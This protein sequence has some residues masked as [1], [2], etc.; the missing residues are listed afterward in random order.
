M[1]KVEQLKREKDS[2][3]IIKDL[4]RFAREGWESI[5]DDDVQRL[6]WYGLFL[7]TPTPGLFM[8]RVRIP[9]GLTDASQ[10]HTLGEISKN[11]GNGVIDITTR[12]QI[13]LRGLKIEDTP[14]VFELMDNVGLTSIQTGQDNVRNIMGCPVAGLNP[15]EVLDASSVLMDLNRHIQGNR[16]FTDLPRKFNAMISGCADNCHHAETQDLALIPAERKDSLGERKGFNVLVGGKLGSGGYRIASPLDVFVT[17]EEV[18]EVCSELILTYRDNGSREIRTQNRLAFL[19]DEWGEERFRRELE[20]RLGRSLDRAGTDLRNNETSKHIGIYRQKQSSMNYIGIRIVVGRISAEKLIGLA[21]VAEQYG[22]GE[23]RLSPAQTMIIPNVADGILGEALEHPLL[24]EFLYYPSGV[25]QDLVS[26]VGNDYC[27]LATIETKSRAV[28]VATKLEKT[29][30]DTVPISMHWSGCPASCGNHLIAD[31]GLLGKRIKV[32]KEV[33]DGVD[34]FMGGRTGKHPKQAIKI[35]E[36]VP[37]DILPNV[38]E[39][40]IPFHTREKM[41]PI[42]GMKKSKNKNKVGASKSRKVEIDRVP[43]VVNGVSTN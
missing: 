13:Q 32:G 20:M 29:L 42:K 38:L 40:I 21:E 5:S 7:R 39:Q 30:K 22:N 31:I 26:C 14:Q 24:K 18:V 35:L 16:T 28:E 15:K 9:G 19:I 27:H 17:Q 8:I 25:S 2:L 37:C 10:I 3:D 36:N 41:H 43:F 12:Q 6:K 23:I 11:F 1:N 34:I 33:V 4:E